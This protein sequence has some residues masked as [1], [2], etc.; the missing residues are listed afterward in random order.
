MIDLVGEPV[1]A[2][3]SAN[4]LAQRS[5]QTALAEANGLLSRLVESV[6]DAALQ[7]R[8]VKIGET[9]AQLQRQSE[10]ICRQHGREVDLVIAG[11]ETEL[12]M[13]VVEKM[14]MPLQHLLRNAL[15]NNIEPTELREAREKASQRHG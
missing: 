7:L 15:L 8:M 13:I 2:G 5:G 10:E 11:A 12:D 4:L 9:F 3:A 14:A 6:R 1:I